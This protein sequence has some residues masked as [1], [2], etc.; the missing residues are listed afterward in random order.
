MIINEKDFENEIKLL[1]NVFKLKFTYRFSERE[2]DWHKESV[3]SHTWAMMV[4]VDIYLEKLNKLSPWKYSLDKLKI[5]EYIIYHDLVEAETWDIDLHPKYIDMHN[6]KSVN[7]KIAFKNLL[8]KIPE[9]LVWPFSQNYMAYENREDLESKFVKLIDVLEVTFQT[10]FHKDF[11][12]N[13]TEKYF[14]SKRKKYF[15]DFPEFKYIF[16][17]ILNYFKKNDYFDK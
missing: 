3:W 11:Y 10:F 1:L 9:E 12:Q 2:I 4:L 17:Y 13:W 14:V 16:D 15:D 8:W 6:K 7:E 5:Y